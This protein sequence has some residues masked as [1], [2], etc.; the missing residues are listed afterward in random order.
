MYLRR[1]GD[2]N[3]HLKSMLCARPLTHPILFTF[4]NLIGRFYYDLTDE[5]IEAEMFN[6]FPKRFYRGGIWTPGGIPKTMSRS[7]RLKLFSQ[8]H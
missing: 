1:G 5:E 4:H 3:S 7:V 8:Q 6:E 2:V